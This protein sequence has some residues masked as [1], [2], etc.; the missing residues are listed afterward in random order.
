MNISSFLNGLTRPLNAILKRSKGAETTAA[1]FAAAPAA[2]KP[3]IEHEMVTRVKGRIRSGEFALQSY[4]PHPDLKKIPPHKLRTLFRD[5]HIIAVTGQR[6]A[7]TAKLKLRVLPGP[8][9]TDE[10]HLFMESALSRLDLRQLV[11]DAT[12]APLYGRQTFEVIWG[13]DYL[14]RDCIGKP[15]E[16]FGWDDTGALC[17]K[18]GQTLPSRAPPVSKFLATAA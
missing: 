5:S 7:G 12:D 17:Y 14:P 3:A 6:K 18:P 1:D 11:D 16:L 10:S 13:S 9:R 8:G 4:L 2:G 15:L